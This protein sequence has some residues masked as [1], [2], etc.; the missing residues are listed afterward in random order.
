[1]QNWQFVRTEGPCWRKRRRDSREFILERRTSSEG[2][3]P[4][5]RMAER[6]VKRT[7]VGI[8]RREEVVLKMSSCEKIGRESMMKELTRRKRR[9]RAR[10]SLRDRGRIGRLCIAGAARRER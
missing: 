5:G 6:R 3:R 7:S 2:V 10:V 4:L 9:R 8:W 1:M